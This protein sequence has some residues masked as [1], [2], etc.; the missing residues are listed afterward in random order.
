[1][2]KLRICPRA[3][4]SAEESLI[5]GDELPPFEDLACRRENC[6]GPMR[7]GGAVIN[8]PGVSKFIVGGTDNCGLSLLDKSLEQ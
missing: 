6:P 2:N 1:M 7:V 8:L 4:R 5:T 3:E